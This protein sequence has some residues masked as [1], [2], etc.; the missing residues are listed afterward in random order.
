MAREQ[1]HES[2]DQE[3]DHGGQDRH[4]HPAT[5]QVGGQPRGRG[6]RGL[7]RFLLTGLGAALDDLLGVG[8]VGAHTVTAASASGSAWPPVMAMPS[9]SSVTSGPNSPAIWPS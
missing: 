1:H 2:G 3:R 4:D 8:L 6:E 7:E 9:V 5:A